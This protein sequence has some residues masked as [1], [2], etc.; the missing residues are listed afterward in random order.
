MMNW[1]EDMNPLLDSMIEG[2]TWSDWHANITIQLGELIEAGFDWGRN[3][4]FKDP[5]FSEKNRTRLNQKIEDRYYY[6][7]ICEVPPGKFRHFLIRKL[8]E[9]L[10]KYNE[11]YKIIDADMLKVL[12][13]ETSNRKYR[14]V[15]SEYPQSQLNGNA[16][17]ATNANDNAGAETVDGPVIE[18]ITEFMD[19]YND[20]DVMILNEINVCFLSLI[21]TSV[22]GF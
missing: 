4:Y 1:K 13:K 14:N 18:L 8:N 9:I 7:E 19:K 21:S 3:E 5:S 22:N 6:R 16:D 2:S 11:I 15:Y 17:Y 10:P 12:R 20:V